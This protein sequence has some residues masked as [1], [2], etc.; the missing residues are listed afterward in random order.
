M[1]EELIIGLVVIFAIGW[2]L[3]AIVNAFLKG[4]SETRKGLSVKIAEVRARRFK[5]RKAALAPLVR[6]ATPDD[7]LR[8]ELVVRQ[9]EGKFQIRRASKLWK[10]IRPTWEKRAFLRQTF[11]PQSVY[12][13]EMN[14][15]E[16]DKILCPETE[17]W[18][19]KE[20]TIF[21]QKCDY[22]SAAPAI[23]CSEF[24]E[25]SWSP[26]PVGEG[27]FE[28]DSETI[29]E[30]D[31]CRYF[32]DERAN[33]SEYNR[34]RAGVLSK[35]A[36]LLKEINSWNAEQRALWNRYVETSAALF[37]E[38]LAKYRQTS[39][40]FVK[41][42][43]GQKD[44]LRSI[45]EGFQNGAKGAVLERVEFILGSLD[46]PDSVPRLW[47]TDYDEEQHILIVELGLPDV[48]HRPP[49]KLVEQRSGLVAKSLNQSERREFIPKVHP[50][51]L[52]R[53]GFEIARNN[54]SKVIKLLVLNGW[55]AFREPTTGL[56]TTAY[57]AS[58]MAEPDQLASLNLRNVDPV[59]A[60]NH[61]HGKSA[62]R[63]IEIV[64]IEPML[65]LKRA[66]S[67]FIEARDV[68]DGLE[69][70]TNLASMDWQDF[71]HLIR[72]LF[73]KEFSGRG[74]EVK[75]TQASRDRGVDAIVFDPD[76]I[77]GGKYVIQAKRYTNTVD[78]SAVRDLCAVVRKEGASRGILVTT[79]TYGAD[80]YVF[81]NN[82]PVTLLSGAELLGLLRKHGYDFKIDLAAARQLLQG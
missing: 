67:R 2:V 64:P 82:E 80:A 66:D 26:L 40:Q 60:F 65:N 70:S 77:H 22:P 8:A 59:A 79:S 76:P 78:V 35:Q 13:S 55:I 61:L 50:A 27:I 42:C 43:T 19:E 21:N 41:D 45:L 58:L 5:K 72:Q 4:M 53:V 15:A 69:G 9:V 56:E 32:G 49:F 34:R 31:I 18:S 3:Y 25:F 48:V 52:L 16:I 7:L 63:L 14:I 24:E 36:A 17:P 62:G 75:I 38:E 29:C 6:V 74:A 71:E 73:E 37:S 12:C 57:T 10:P 33:V 54:T 44:K 68:I 81:A 20:V 23:I 47:K 28:F 30:K 46:L 1:P 51:I 11:L 39:E